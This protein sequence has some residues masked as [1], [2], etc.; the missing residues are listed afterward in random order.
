MFFQRERD[1]SGVLEIGCCVPWRVTKSKE[2]GG[3]I[4]TMSHQSETRNK[5]GVSNEELTATAENNINQN[6]R[7]MLKASDEQMMTIIK[8]LFYIYKLS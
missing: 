7:V 4:C 3:E 1:T 5:F 8:I 6:N 2:R